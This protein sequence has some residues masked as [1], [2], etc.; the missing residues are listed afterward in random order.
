MNETA[1]S[2]F[3]PARAPHVG[4]SDHHKR[5]RIISVQSI[6]CEVGKIGCFSGAVKTH[7]ALRGRTTESDKFRFYLQ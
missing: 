4:A 2:A 1:V 7:D 3:D 6:L 5:A